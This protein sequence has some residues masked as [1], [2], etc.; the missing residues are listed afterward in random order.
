[1]VSVYFGFSLYHSTNDS[2]YSFI[3]EA[4]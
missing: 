2:Y 4:T 1:V 3:T